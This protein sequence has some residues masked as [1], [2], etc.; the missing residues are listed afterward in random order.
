MRS[1]FAHEVGSTDYYYY[2]III[3]HQRTQENLLL[4]MMMTGDKDERSLALCK[5]I[6]AM[7]V[8]SSDPA[9]PVRKFEPPTLNFN[10]NGLSDMI[11]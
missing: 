10:C 6:Q 9:L 1:F 8:P 2:W 4:C 5:I 7:D 11:T 3:V